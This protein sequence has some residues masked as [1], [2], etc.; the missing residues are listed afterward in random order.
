MD[1]ALNTFSSF[2]GHAVGVVGERTFDALLYPLPEADSPFSYVVKSTWVA[3][4]AAYVLLPNASAA[5]REET[6]RVI[7]SVL[8]VLVRLLAS[9]VGR[10]QAARVLGVLALLLAPLV[11]NHRF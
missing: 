6:R 11:I 8:G 5:E 9:V 4:S 1:D 10:R 3:T 7:D 2:W